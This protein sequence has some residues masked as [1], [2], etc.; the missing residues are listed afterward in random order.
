MDRIADARF[1]MAVGASGAITGFDAT[2]RMPADEGALLWIEVAVA[3]TAGIGTVTVNYTDQS[4]IAGT[5]TVT[6]VVTAIVG[7]SINTSLWQPLA[8]GNFGIRTI[9][10]VTIT[11]GGTG[12]IDV[13]LVRPVAYVP[14][15]GN[16]TLDNNM[17]VQRAIMPRVYDDACL[18]LLFATASPVGQSYRGSLRAVS[19]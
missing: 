14:A 3:T 19:A 9:T 6:P 2:S 7:S 8:A 13:C 5:T 1:D 16:E 4:G 18:A 11:A 10:S 12:S 17:A 15:L